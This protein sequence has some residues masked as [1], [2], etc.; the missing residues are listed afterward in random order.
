MPEATALQGLTS[1]E[2]RQRLL[3]YGPNMV[4]ED[5][6]HPWLLLLRKFWAPVPWMLEATIALQFALG[7][8]DEAAI[9]AVLLIFNAVLGFA[10]ENRANNALALLKKRLAIQVRVFR[11]KIWQQAAAQDLVPGDVVHLRMGDFAPADM[12]RWNESLFSEAELG[13]ISG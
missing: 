5:H 12:L 13:T 7:K 11:D 6:P 8:A 3:K 1:A 10:Q 2:A 9:I 4:A